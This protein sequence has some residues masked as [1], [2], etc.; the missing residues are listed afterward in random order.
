MVINC[1]NG[2]KIILD[3]NLTFSDFDRETLVDVFSDVVE[4]EC[5]V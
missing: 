4:N 3:N 1:S 2:N 5:Y